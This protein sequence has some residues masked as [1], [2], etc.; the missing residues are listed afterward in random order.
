MKIVENINRQ[1]ESEGTPPLSLERLRKI[2]QGAVGR[3]HIAQML[4]ERGLAGDMNDAFDSFL[5]PHNVPKHKLAIQEAIR[6]IKDE[7]GWPV[8]AHPHVLRNSP[9]H[10]SA[11]GSRKLVSDFARMGVEGLESY[12]GEYNCYESAL[13]TDWALNLDLFVTIGSDFHGFAERGRMGR[14]C[15][16]SVPVEQIM[17]N[18]PF[19]NKCDN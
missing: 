2:A 16:G 1:L 3:P 18:L 17:K 5:V 4:I 7:G 12:Y 9:N 14:F 8:L 19:V 15:C 11:D 13:Y 10:L 6:L